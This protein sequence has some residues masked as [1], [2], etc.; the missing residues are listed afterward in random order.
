MLNRA[1]TLHCVV[2]LLLLSGIGFGQIN[3]QGTPRTRIQ[4]RGLSS[5]QNDNLR[6]QERERWLI[7]QQANMRQ[8]ERDKNASIRPPTT[9]PDGKPYNKAELKKIKALLEPNPE[10][11]AKYKDFLE[12]PKT[13]MFRL[14]PDFECEIKNVI[15]ADGDCENFI[16]GGWVY[17]FRLKTRNA[18]FLSDIRF[19]GED[20]ITD[21]FLAQGI[22][23]PLGDIGLETISLNSEG[24]KFLNDYKPAVQSREAKKQF[25][26]I[27]N[28]FAFD[29]FRYAKRVRAIANINYAMRVIAYRND[30]VGGLIDFD[31]RMDLTVVFRIV[32]KDE[33]GGITILWKE[34]KRQD[35][36]KL[37]FQKG[38]KLVDINQN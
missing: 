18:G 21:G 33:N 11:L 30:N 5:D 9:K 7:Q 12:Q 35:A 23:V 34:L 25:T 4:P 1:K 2:C 37:I 19:S 6:N 10:D 24:M 26:Q 29:G 3:P 32:R 13:G 17:S 22:L 14:F 27:A 36:P 38:E 31:K 15:R 20:L 8:L 28:V 16:P